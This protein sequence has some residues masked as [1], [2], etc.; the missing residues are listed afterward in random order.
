MGV[1]GWLLN[2]VMGFLTDREMFLR[3]KGE[4]SNSKPLPGGGP[5]GTLLGLLLFLVLINDCGFQCKDESESV[6]EVL[7]QK[8]KRFQSPVMH[9]KYVDD[10]TIL[11]ALNLK[12]SLI[13][14]PER[15]LPDTY[16]S[17]L[18]LKLDPAKSKVYHEID[19][20]RRYA[21]DNEMKL[22]VRKCK[23]ILST[24]L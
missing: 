7:T 6:G 9:I 8:K 3:Y 22:N 20:I 4:T 2:L 12:E 11:E 18:G 17:R 24:L 5:Q 21:N 10:L 14:N 16:H 1:P 23:F 19:N 15:P 13:P